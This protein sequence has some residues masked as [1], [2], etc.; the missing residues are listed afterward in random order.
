MNTNHAEIEYLRSIIF[1]N[2]D[3]L[4]NSDYCLLDVPNHKNIGDNLIWAGELAYLNRLPFKM[5]YTSN[6][7]LFEER[8]INKGDIILLNGG[9]NF[10]DLYRVIQEFRIKVISS[11]PMN[12][13]VIFPVTAQYIDKGILARD[14]E[15][16][17]SHPD[18][19]ICARDKMT[20]DFLKLNF[21]FNNILLIPDMAFC[22]SFNPVVA[23]GSSKKRIL[24]LKRTDGEFNKDTQELGLIA[25]I[26]KAGYHLDIQDWPTFNKGKLQSLLGEK[27]YGIHR[28]IARMLLNLPIL[29]ELVDPRYGLDRSRTMD[30]YVELG[31]CFLERYDEIYTTRL[32]VY[33][34][35][36]LL[37]KKVTIIDN[38]YGKNRGLYE[39]WMKGFKNSFIR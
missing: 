29:N 28:R 32:H 19:T 2:L 9:G 16:F 17:Q 39:T 31:R 23:K 21:P 13:I 34:L 26:K 6:L 15:V 35:S 18:L 10:G 8:R 5:K 3:P 11:F 4:I 22:L 30:T 38:S 25:E 36:I 12:R 37:D 1:K 27:L 7:F 33:I 14:V 20:Y 24:Y